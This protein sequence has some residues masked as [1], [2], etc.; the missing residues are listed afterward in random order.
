MAQAVI[1]VRV[2]SADKQK[3]EVF[4]N[5]VGM[6]IS[7]AMNMF[8]K[9]VLRDY[10][11]PFEVGVDVPNARLQAAIEEGERIAKDPN[12]KA[13]HSMKELREALEEN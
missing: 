12:V 13:Y 2:D 4:C 6:N 7:T 9:K 10:K 11:L 1:N 5:D 3:F 8:I